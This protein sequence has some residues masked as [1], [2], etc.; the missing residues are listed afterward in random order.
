MVFSGITALFTALWLV[1]VGFVLLQIFGRVYEGG[2]LVFAGLFITAPPVF[3]STLLALL[4]VGPR[5]CKVAW[6]SA[7]LWL[8]PVAVGLVGAL[9]FSMHK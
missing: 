4:L 9:V 6:I 7:L 2:E 8:S 1:L 5:N 3:I